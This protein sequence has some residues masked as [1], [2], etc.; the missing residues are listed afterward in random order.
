MGGAPAKGKAGLSAYLSDMAS[1][2]IL[3]VDDVGLMCTQFVAMVKGQWHLNLLVGAE[4]PSGDIEAS[5][6]AAVGVILARYARQR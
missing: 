6:R 4:V 1:A 3:E 2:G 5:V